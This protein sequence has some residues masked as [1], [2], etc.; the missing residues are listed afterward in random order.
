MRFNIQHGETS[1]EFHTHGPYRLVLW[2]SKY[3]WFPKNISPPDGKNKMAAYLISVLHLWSIFTPCTHIFTSMITL[4]VFLETNFLFIS[5]FIVTF[6]SLMKKISFLKFIK[7]NDILYIYIL[8]I[9][10]VMVWHS[11]CKKT[12][13]INRWRIVPYFIF[14]SNN[15]LSYIIFFSGLFLFADYYFCFRRIVYVQISESKNQVL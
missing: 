4:L 13:S 15:F 7:R 3:P 2:S 9:W 10:F 12:D 14:I 5:T 8:H 1:L 11:W 6:E